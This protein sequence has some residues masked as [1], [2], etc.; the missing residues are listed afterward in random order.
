LGFSWD[1]VL[2]V[3][4]VPFGALKKPETEISE[5]SAILCLIL[6]FKANSDK[7]FNLISPL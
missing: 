5:I 2:W 3:S 7:T 4:S 6:A 1:G